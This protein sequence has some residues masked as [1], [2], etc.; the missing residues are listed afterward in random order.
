[1]ELL[2]L[3]SLSGEDTFFGRRARLKYLSWYSDTINQLT[4]SYM[5]LRETNCIL[6]LLGIPV[7]TD[8]EVVFWT[9]EVI[10]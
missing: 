8:P 6:L 4:S 3:V 7:L 5:L 1:M 9:I 2:L 10:Q